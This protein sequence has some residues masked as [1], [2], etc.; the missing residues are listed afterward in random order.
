VLVVTLVERV[1]L[2]PSEK[3]FSHLRSRQHPPSS[4]SGPQG[5]KTEEDELVERKEK[6]SAE[7]FPRESHQRML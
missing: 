5:A 2:V 6:A 1:E 7:I 4:Q 3:I